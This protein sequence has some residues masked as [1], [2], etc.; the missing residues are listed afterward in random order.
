M[1]FWDIVK[2]E[3]KNVVQW[4]DTSMKP[5]QEVKDNENT[6][7][8]SI[9]GKTNKQQAN[10]PP[11][12]SFR[13]YPREMFAYGQSPDSSEL[14]IM[15]FVIWLHPSHVPWLSLPS[16]SLFPKCLVLQPKQTIILKT[17]CML[18]SFYEVV[19]SITKAPPHF[20]LVNTPYSSHEIFTVHLSMNN[21][22]PTIQYF[23]EKLVITWLIINS[24]HLYSTYSILLIIFLLLLLFLSPLLLF[25]LYLFLF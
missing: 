10:Q 22:S 2:I 21:F 15:P 14:Y 24:T 25:L 19:T 5:K 13:V 4:E 12:K 8:F 17:H 23:N 11:L 9:P 16:H 7:S 3:T 1:F 18:L 20:Y 6:S